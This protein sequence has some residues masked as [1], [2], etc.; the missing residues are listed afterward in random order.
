MAREVVLPRVDMD[1]ATGRMGRWFVNEGE[2]V[3]EG[4]PLF[5]IEADAAAVEVEAPASGLL[6]GVRAKGGDVLPVGAVLAWIVGEDEAFDPDLQALA[7][8]LR[9]LLASFAPPA[10]RASLAVEAP[11]AVERRRRPPPARG[12]A[13]SGCDGARARRW[14]FCTASASTSTAGAPLAAFLPTARPALALGLP[15]HGGSPLVGAPS[16]AALVAAAR[17][18]LAEEGIGA[19]HLIGHCLGGAVAAGSPPSRDFARCR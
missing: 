4:Q 7:G 14:R 9:A 8:E 15:G 19:A 6:R 1:M 11:A 2:R 16:F 18:A 12:S 13:A 3:S 5:S 10:E 17:E